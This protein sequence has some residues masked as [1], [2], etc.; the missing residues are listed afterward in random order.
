MCV[1]CVI[2]WTGC[3]SFKLISHLP[4]GGRETEGQSVTTQLGETSA[5]VC[6]FHPAPTGGVRAGVMLSGWI[7][8][9]LSLDF[10]SNTDQCLYVGESCQA[11]GS[12]RPAQLD[13]IL[14]K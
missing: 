8:R 5:D 2:V 11:A 1:Q 9:R 10:H 6:G 7:R 14:I 4:P 13:G 3:S 12:S